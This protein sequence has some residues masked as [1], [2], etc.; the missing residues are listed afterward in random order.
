MKVCMRCFVSGRVQ[1][2][3]FRASARHEA[4]Q[5]GVTGYVR[6]L[7]DGRVEGLACGAKTSVDDLCAWLAKGPQHA[8]VCN[9]SCEVATDEPPACFSIE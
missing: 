2:V 3:F 4:E 7:F 8:E 1:G 9:L 5:L 6:N